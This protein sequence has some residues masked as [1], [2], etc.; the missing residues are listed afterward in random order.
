MPPKK[1]IEK[2]SAPKKPTR[3]RKPTKKAANFSTN[4]NSAEKI[5]G[6]LKK[7]DYLFIINWLKIKKNYD[8][9]FGTGKAPL[10]GQPPKGTINGFELMAINLQNQS[11]SKKSYF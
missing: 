8:A 6:H 7:E 2:K 10:V 5:T 4:N 11:L 3:V 9:C 1:A